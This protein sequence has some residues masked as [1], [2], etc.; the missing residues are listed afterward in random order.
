MEVGRRQWSS[1][2]RIVCERARSRVS[3]NRVRNGNEPRSTR[4]T[5]ST[6]ETMVLNRRGCLGDYRIPRKYIYIYIHD[7]ARLIE[8]NRLF[9][10]FLRFLQTNRLSIKYFFFFFFFF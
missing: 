6:R 2:G 1:N 10:I 7:A 8:E 3:V 9:R 5:I 4:E